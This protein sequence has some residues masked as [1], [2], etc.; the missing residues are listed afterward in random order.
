MKL[1]KTQLKE[2]IREEI[3]SLNENKLQKGDFVR[4]YDKYKGGKMDW[5]I[6][7]IDETHVRVTTAKPPTTSGMVVHVRQLQERP[8]YKDMMK[9]IETGNPKHI[10][11]KTYSDP[12]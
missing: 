5:Y 11:G 9:W 4:Y 7:F 6:V 12:E 2:I 3:K 1:T 10:D 8:Y